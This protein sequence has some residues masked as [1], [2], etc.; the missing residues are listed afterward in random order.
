MNRYH[1]E[2]FNQPRID[3]EHGREPMEP[4]SNLEIICGIISGI[5]ILCVVVVFSSCGPEIL[6]VLG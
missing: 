1:G 2:R 6:E 3:N 5:A 4:L